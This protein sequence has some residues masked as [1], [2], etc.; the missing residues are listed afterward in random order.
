MRRVVT[1]VPALR[2]A[3]VGEWTMTRYAD[4]QR[5]PDC[6]NPIVQGV[7]TCPTCGLPLHGLLAVELFST[8]S[9]ADDLIVR[10]RQG[11]P[12]APAAPA[13]PTGHPP[14][15]HPPP[16]DVPTGLTTASVPRILLGL[17]ALC[18]LVAALVFLAV[19]WSAMGVGGRTATL[20]GFTAVAAGLTAWGARRDLRAAVE[21][22]GVVTLGLLAF[23]L[24]G[25]REAGWFGDVGTPAFLLLLGL[26][27]LVT[28]GSAALAVRRTPA[29]AFRGGEVVAAVGLVSAAIGAASADWLSLA[30]GLT[31]A[32]AACWG[33]VLA[34]AALRLG[35]LAW[36]A[37]VVGAWVW[38]L[39]TVSSLVR[40]LEHP[41]LSE[42]WLDL[43]VWPLVAAA[44]LAGA[45]GLTRLPMVLRVGALALAAV[46]GAGVLLVPLTDEPATPAAAGAAALL[47]GLS[48]LTWVTPRP[49][50]AAPA[51]PVG[52]GVVGLGASALSLALSSVE[53]LVMEGEDLWSGSV[54]TVLPPAVPSDDQLAGW[55]LPLL[56]VATV[57]GLAALGRASAPL[58]ELLLP[59]LNPDV[60][61]GVAV[62]TFALTLAAHAVPVGL[63][64]AVF[65]LGGAVLVGRA[66]TTGAGRALVVGAGLLV[67]ALLSALPSAGL[68]L[69]VLTTT[70]LA[71]LLLHLRGAPVMVRDVAGAVVGP[72][73]AGAVAAAGAL[74]DADERW[75]AL[76]ALLALAALV[77]ALPYAVR[78]GALSGPGPLGGP[79]ALDVPDPLGGPGR[80]SVRSVSL[81]VGSLAAAVLA[82]VAALGGLGED[83]APTWA[84]VYLTVAGTTASAMAVLRADRRLVGWLGGLLLAAAS[85][86]RLWDIGVETPEA[87][88]LPSAVALLG[89]GVWRLRHTPGAGTLRAL[90]PG[91]LLAL[92][93]SLVWAF[94]EPVSVRSLLLGAACLA[95]VVAGVRL[96]WAAPLVCGAAVGA[97]LV[98]RLATPVAEAV[99]RWALI[100]AAGVLLV[101]AGITWEQRLRDARAVAGYVRRMR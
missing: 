84:A 100:G 16:G 54:V 29:G 7:A 70:C 24:V 43:E 49:W 27:L 85:W 10:M 28:G 68:T 91:L 94:D 33:T 47:V 60:L 58:R 74:V 69:L 45:L 95:L 38:A 63:V 17:G 83:Q 15:G 50:R 19:A 5:C 30:A 71:A 96:H 20:L 12:Y 62:V 53:R 13:T 66:L 81:E 3:D 101:A 31:L 44:V 79:D 26:V 82:S 76:A 61:A 22:L 48:A 2:V 99:P 23:D 25:A 59:L 93:P 77:L 86:V 72:A 42:L 35:V 32:V 90:G 64:V 67:L 9:A 37:G 57:S 88:T 34:A 39:L 40:A 41:S 97:L 6:R 56:V 80:A 11:A 92:V 98:L 73:L 55:I 18:L 36:G 65:T 14:T 8:L 21:S 52:I 89:V 46:V 87:Y 4:P 1:M 51:V 75:T 78:G